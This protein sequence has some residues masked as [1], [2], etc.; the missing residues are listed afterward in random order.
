MA[1]NPNQK[2]G[3][4]EIDTLVG[5]AWSQHY[6][7]ENDAAINA[8]KGLVERATD[9]ID[10]NFGLALSLKKA[11]RKDEAVAAFNKAK[12]LVQA[13][14]VGDDADANAKNSML[15]RMIEQHLASLK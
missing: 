11:G 5:Q 4:N 7:G 15:L 10:A 9:H 8:F 12:G 2:V 1:N 3:S 13:N 14:N 6:H